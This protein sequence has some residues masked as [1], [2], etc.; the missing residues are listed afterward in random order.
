MMAD[1]KRYEELIN[2]LD[3]YSY[4]YYVIDNP[5]VEDAEYDQKMQELLKIE[6]SSEPSNDARFHW[7]YSGIFA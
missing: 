3:Q 4:D 6:D 1:K 5:T 2:I 7:F